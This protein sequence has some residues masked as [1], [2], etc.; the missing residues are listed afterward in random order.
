MAR[1]QGF[2]DH[3]ASGKPPVIIFEAYDHSLRKMGSSRV[4]VLE[5]LLRADTRTIRS[6]IGQKVDHSDR[7]GLRPHRGS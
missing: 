4:A 1:V 3:L 2:K 5:L 7:R 6:T